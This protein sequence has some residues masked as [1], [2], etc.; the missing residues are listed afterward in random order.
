MADVFITVD[1]FNK[2][3]LAIPD[4]Y[5]L[6][7]GQIDLDKLNKDPDIDSSLKE[8]VDFWFNALVSYNHKIIQGKKKLEY[9][10]HSRRQAECNSRIKKAMRTPVWGYEP[11]WDLID[12]IREEKRN[13]D[14]D[15]S[16]WW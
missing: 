6:A 7:N 10:N 14:N 5:F 3:Q 11:D 12:R 8:K 15:G 16:Y 2:T 13:Q 4:K 9:N 1:Q